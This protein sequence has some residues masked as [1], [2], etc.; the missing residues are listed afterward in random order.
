MHLI[1]D[2]IHVLL[3]HH[4]CVIVPQFGGF[5]TNLKPAHIHPRKHII[6][7]PSKQVSFNKHLINNDGLL[8]NQVAQDQGLSYDDALELVKQHVADLKR[9]LLSGKRIEF[10]NV[11][12]LYLNENQAWQFIPNQQV[13]FLQSSYGL[14]P[15]ALS[16]IEAAE[17]PAEEKETP[18]VAIDQ[19]KE[20]EIIVVAAKKKRHYWKVAVLA[21]PLLAAAYFVNAPL[22]EGESTLSLVNLDAFKQQKVSSYEARFEEEDIR[23]EH[24]K[25]E[26]AVDML[27]RDYPSMES[28]Y[29]S[30]DDHRISPEGY[31]I[32]MDEKANEA[33]VVETPD[34]EENKASSALNLH[35][36]I[37]GAFGDSQNAQNLLADLR[38]DGFDAV[39][40]G[41]SGALEL[42]AFGSYTTK[43]AARKA[44][45]EI[46]AKGYK[47]AWVK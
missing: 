37:A 10:E 11:G 2:Y 45:K 34:V 20:P 22:W 43:K 41:K 19:N 26:N 46:K 44:L 21:I 13:N 7:P 14:A 38:S 12:V 32:R 35:F 9:D 47:Q 39:I 33:A 18:V 23:F 31:L 24:E 17:V 16:L 15:V 36:V 6:V 27:E 29:F 8:V 5:V 42:V 30:F 3:F 40:A 4:D 28:V 1:S 25:V